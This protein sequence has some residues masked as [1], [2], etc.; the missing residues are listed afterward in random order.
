[1]EHVF[2]VS[3][4]DNDRIHKRI[5]KDSFEIFHSYD[6]K[7][8]AK[9]G[10]L[11]TGTSQYSYPRGVAI[12]PQLRYAYIV[13]NGNHRIKKIDYDDLSYIL[14]RGSYG[15]GNDNYKYPSGIA[16]SPDG[17]Y[18]VITDSNNHR[19]K[20]IRCSDLYYS[21]KLGSLGTGDSNFSS[22]EG[23]C[24]S[25]DGLYIFV[26]D[27]ANHRIKKHLFSTLAYSANA[28][29]YGSGENQ[30]N[31][32]RGIAIG[33]DGV[34]LYVMDSENHRVV[35][36]LASDMSYVD[37]CGSYGTGN[38]EFDTPTGCS[39]TSDGKFLLVIDRKND[40]I[41]KFDAETL[42]YIS[43][44]GSI[45]SGDD[46]FYA[47]M[48]GAFGEDDYLLISDTHN[49]RVKKH[50][51]LYQ[52][53]DLVYDSEYGSNGA[54]EDELD[55]PCGIA[56]S[57]DKNMIAIADIMN[58]RVV[59]RDFETLEFLAE[60]TADAQNCVFSPDNLYLFLVEYLPT[61]GLVKKY[62]LA[63]LTLQEESVENF[64]EAKGI[65][66]TPD[67][68]HI[69]VADSGNDRIVR[70]LASDLT[71]VDSI[72][73][74]GAG[75]DQYSAPS[76]IAV[77]PDGDYFLV[78]DTNNHRIVKCTL[79]TLGYYDE[80]GSNG[81]GNDNFGAPSAISITADGLFFVVAD[82]N[83]NRIKKHLFSD[84]SY[85][86]EIGTFGTSGDDCFN[87]PGGIACVPLGVTRV[88][89][90]TE[91]GATYFYDKL[92]KYL[93]DFVVVNDILTAIL[94]GL[95]VPLLL[96]KKWINASTTYALKNYKWQG[97]PLLQLAKEAHLFLNDDE[98]DRQIQFLVE[99]ALEI[100]D[101]RGTMAGLREDLLR[102]TEDDTLLI[103]EVDENQSGWWLDLSYPT[104]DDDGDPDPNATASW[105][106]CIDQVNITLLN[107]NGK[108]SDAKISEITERY[109]LPGNVTANF[110]F[111]VSLIWYISVNLAGDGM[112]MSVDGVN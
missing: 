19:L 71:L 51:L 84:M 95:E 16:I 33:P 43:K 6:L 13:E 99:H 103:E 100:H 77:H 72:G 102:M 104:I 21:A 18:L 68:V 44:I 96:A 58:V 35:K 9:Q 25:P 107:S 89:T 78:A 28:G 101:Q 90:L 64:D 37:E 50:R 82:P 111:G 14:V 85:I 60:L 87:A 24:I 69:L 31:S 105:L 3:D 112:N 17:S 86:S 48:F 74:T 45:G 98:T 47:P 66:V 11:G 12:D 75:D 2:F 26:T 52:Y 54:G 62:D 106:N 23:C 4:S 63:T 41:Q 65:A 1:M 108:Y 15:T 56:V 29:S 38:G 79:S 36:L 76:G 27:S 49:H 57:Q 10:S 46:Q 32:P 73:T 20:K 80:I 59:F 92:V 70:L 8:V 39:V 42:E 91:P 83:N 109:L 53:A 67:G 34:Y 30:Y 81:T 55:T 97:T 94:K 61:T 40:R 22:P 7:Y 93:P 5:L 88:A 110:K